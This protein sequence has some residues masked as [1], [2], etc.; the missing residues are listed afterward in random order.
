MSSSAASDPHQGEVAAVLEL[1]RRF[2]RQ[3]GGFANKRL[4]NLTRNEAFA[5]DD[6]GEKDRSAN[7]SFYGWFCQMHAFADDNRTVRVRLHGTLPAGSAFDRW[8]AERSLGNEVV[9][10]TIT[11]ERLGELTSLASCVE[12]G[13][14][15]KSGRLMAQRTAKSIRRL[16]SFL[17]RLWAADARGSSATE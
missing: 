15:G 7:G 14:E 11:P 6:R 16:H 10:F 2:F 9:E 5:V 3:Y 4:K 1:R 8:L 12:R 13:G 17:A